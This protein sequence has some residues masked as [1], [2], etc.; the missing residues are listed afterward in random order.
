MGS[1]SV[2]ALGPQENRFSSLIDKLVFWFHKA[3][4]EGEIIKPALKDAL[5]HKGLGNSFLLALRHKTTHSSRNARIINAPGYLWD[6]ASPGPW[7]CC[8]DS[9][10]S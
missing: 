8:S 9:T 10:G 7:Q 2:C 6:R 5:S 3:V 4:S 1:H